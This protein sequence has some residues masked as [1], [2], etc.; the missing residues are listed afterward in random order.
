MLKETPRSLRAYFALVTLFWFLGAFG[1]YRQAGSNHVVL[2]LAGLSMLLCVLYAYVVTRFPHLLRDNP[3]FLKNTLTAGLIYSLGLT[4]LSVL[5]GA[6]TG[7]LIRI[8]IAIAVYLYLV[9]S[10]NRLS[11][12]VAPPPPPETL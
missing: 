7:G 1:G 10:V 3:V 4:V 5:N 2:F 11:A 9:K 6:A 12:E 8:L